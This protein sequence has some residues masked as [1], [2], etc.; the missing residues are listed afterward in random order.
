MAS[1]KLLGVV[2][3]AAPG[4]GAALAVRVARSL[5]GRWGRL[6]PGERRRLQ[7]LAEDAK[8]QALDL[9]GH[10]DPVAASSRLRASSQSLAEAL[11]ESA[12]ADP[13]VDDLEVRRLRDELRRELDRVAGSESGPSA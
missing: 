9:R 8:R 12:Q 10:P 3:V 1:N 13:E 6:S 11:V 4:A 5:Y 7:T 2:R